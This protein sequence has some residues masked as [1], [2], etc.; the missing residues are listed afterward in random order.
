[1]TVVMLLVIAGVAI[2]V[3][4]PLLRA[5]PGQQQPQSQFSPATGNDGDSS[6]WD[7]GT[8]PA[9]LGIVASVDTHLDHS[10]TH[11]D[12]EVAA[13]ESGWGE[14][15]ASSSWSEAGDGGGYDSSGDSGGSDGGDGGG[16]SD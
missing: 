13:G 15:G 4:V 1:M 12:P 14:H 2:L 8:V 16:G 6:T 11:R 7:F 5:R 10:G 3:L 9:A